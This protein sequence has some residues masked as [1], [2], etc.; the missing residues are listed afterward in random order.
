MIDYEIIYSTRRTISI[1]VKK[2]GSVLFRAPYHTPKSKFEKLIIEHNDWIIKHQKRAIERTQADAKL[3]DEIIKILKK[4]A[5]ERLIPMTEYFAS[6]LGVA[7]GKITITSAK[8]R[9]GS[10]SSK[11]NISYSFLLMQYPVQAQEYVVVHELCHRIHMD[12]SPA[13]YKKIE[14]VLPDYKERKK[15]LKNIPK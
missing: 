14:S 12:H 8:T 4:E 5:K 6:I 13:F 3:T 15:L 10:C 9:F 2:D 11:G 1:I 7:Y